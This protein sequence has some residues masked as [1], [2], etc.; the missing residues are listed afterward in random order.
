MK[1][2]ENQFLNSW[3][4]PWSFC[5]PHSRSPHVHRLSILQTNLTLH[6]QV[7]HQMLWTA[8]GDSSPF[9][10]TF[11]FWRLSSNLL[12]ALQKKKPKNPQHPKW[13]S[14]HI[15]QLKIITWMLVSQFPCFTMSHIKWNSWLRTL[16]TNLVL[17]AAGAPGL[18]RAYRYLS[19]PWQGDHPLKGRKMS[20]LSKI[21]PDTI[22]QCCP[23]CEHSACEEQARKQKEVPGDL[24]QHTLGWMCSTAH[25]A[26]CTSGLQCEA[27][28]ESIMERPPGR[29]QTIEESCCHGFFRL[30]HLASF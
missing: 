8:F 1:L 10:H 7:L 12:F 18:L 11:H 19:S 9:F 14:L 15:P 23:S 6:S 28:A 29:K 13:T 16:S 21:A 25:P 17:E 24:V 22:V 27:A 20:F 30:R 26:G 2:E 4:P 5:K 3:G